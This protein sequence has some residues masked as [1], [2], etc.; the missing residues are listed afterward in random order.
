MSASGDRNMRASVSGKIYCKV[1]NTHVDDNPIAL[2]HHYQ[3]NR[4]KR[5]V[6]ENLDN[7]RKEK[8]R[9]N[10]LQRKEISEIQRMQRQA[11]ITPTVSHSA[12][13]LQSHHRNQY[14]EYTSGVCFN[15]Q[16]GQCLYGEECKYKHVFD[17]V[18]KKKKARMDQE[19]GEGGG[20]GS[21]GSTT[22]LGLGFDIKQ[23]REGESGGVSESDSEEEVDETERRGMYV[24]EG[25]VYLDGIKHPD[26]LILGRQVEVA[27][28]DQFDSGDD[29]DDEG[30]E[31][32]K[33]EDDEEGEKEE[34]NPWTTG[35]L[36]SLLYT[37][38]ETPSSAPSSSSSSSSASSSSSS[39][40][41]E[42]QWRYRVT[43]TGGVDC[44]LEKD[45]LLEDLRIPW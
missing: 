32:G 23:A 42:R 44:G 2:S 7:Q 25:R 15:Y 33:G 30:K 31:Q 11:G 35:I 41:E 29:D 1:C 4:H 20:N 16:K 36:S 14:E 39:S 26:Q 27:L 3:G 17:D 8:K 10:S 18:Q 34:Y 43:L 28:G 22:G 45:V 13:S 5:N 12:S 9:N 40:A 38:I 6:R 24:M 37:D 19:N 21:H